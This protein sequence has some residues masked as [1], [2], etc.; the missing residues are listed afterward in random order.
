LARKYH[1]DVHKSE[2]SKSKAAE[3]FTQ[4]A[5]AYE[6]L[7]DEEQRKEYDYM[8][9]NPDEVYRN[10]YYYYRRRYT[11]KV[12]VRIVIVV[13]I[14][15]ISIVQYWASLSKYNEAI[16]HFLTVPKYR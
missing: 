13:T 1:P 5:T 10:Y 9:D 11:P 15:V 16:D 14:S 6:I 7:K 3:L 4:L 2:E 8:L 12:D